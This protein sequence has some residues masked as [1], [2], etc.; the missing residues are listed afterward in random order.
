[1]CVCVC[2]TWC[3]GIS[4]PSPPSEPFQQHYPLLEIRNSFRQVNPFAKVVFKGLFE[5]LVTA[6]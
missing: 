3:N 5:F 2:V 1:M 6:F 4:Q